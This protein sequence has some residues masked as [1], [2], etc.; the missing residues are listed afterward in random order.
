[1]QAGEEFVAGGFFFSGGHYPGKIP[2]DLTYLKLA[3]I[4]DTPSPGSTMSGHNTVLPIQQGPL[5]KC[6]LFPHL[7][8]IHLLGIG[9]GAKAV[10]NR[11]LPKCMMMGS[12]THITLLRD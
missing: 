8:T 4:A 2:L 11:Q 5:E 10:G 1:M 3:T 12:E 9:I 7:G 6:L